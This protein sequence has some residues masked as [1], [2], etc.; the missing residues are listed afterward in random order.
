[1][2]AYVQSQAQQALYTVDLD[3]QTT[4]M[5]LGGGSVLA[6]AGQVRLGVSS[7]AITR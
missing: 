7:T 3:L 5:T 6:R 1:M 2:R 4:T